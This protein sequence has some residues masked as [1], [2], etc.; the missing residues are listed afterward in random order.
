MHTIMELV[1]ATEDI[2]LSPHL[3]AHILMD[4]YIWFV[5][6]YFVGY[7]ILKWVKTNLFAH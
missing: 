7:F 1:G 6:E 3:F 4:V 5:S 2:Y